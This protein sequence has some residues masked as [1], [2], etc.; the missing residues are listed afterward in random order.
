MADES[1]DC[2]YL[3]V[4]APA[5]CTAKGGRAVMVWIHGGDLTSG[6]SS[7]FDGSSIAANQHV[8]VVTFNY[9]VNGIS[10]SYIR[11]LDMVNIRAA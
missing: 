5:G 11:A 10:Q 4:Y 8:V 2:L 1:E 7:A 9:R 6:T 3:N